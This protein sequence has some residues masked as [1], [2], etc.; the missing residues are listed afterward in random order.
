MKR[1]ILFSMIFSISIIGFAQ[2]GEKRLSKPVKS[3]LN[4]SVNDTLFHF[5]GYYYFIN[6]LDYEDFVIDFIDLDSLTPNAS[7]LE[8]TD[9]E[10]FYRELAPGDTLSWVE[11]TSWFDPEGQADDWITIGPITI[12]KSGAELSWKCFY[13]DS[14]RN[15]YEVLITTSGM[16]NYEDFTNDPLFVVSDLYDQDNNGIDT[17]TLFNDA[18]KSINIPEQYKDSAIYIAF[19]HDATNM[20]II[21]FT[22]IVVKEKYTQSIVERQDFGKVYTYPNPAKDK[23][24]VGFYLSKQSDIILSIIDL[25]GNKVY[26]QK[27]SDVLPGQHYI[28]LNLRNLN[29]GLYFYSLSDG[30]NMISK[31]LIIR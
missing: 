17:N 7:S 3:I 16:N 20:D 31:K 22:D 29:S 6:A 27:M 23:T 5:D 4:R 8:T 15:G 24:T 18:P 11:A 12:P 9:W 10:F 1:F 21:H 25:S 26:N 28:D 30:K 14:Y 19:H 2:H 13:N